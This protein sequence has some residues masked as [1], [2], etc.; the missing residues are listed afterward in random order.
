MDGDISISS[1]GQS[2]SYHSYHSPNHFPLSL[3]FYQHNQRSHVTFV[4]SLGLNQFISFHSVRYH[5]PT[6][7]SSSLSLPVLTGPPSPCLLFRLCFSGLH[8]D[9]CY[10]WEARP[11]SSQPFPTSRGD[12]RFRGFRLLF[13]FR[14]FLFHFWQHHSSILL[15]FI[16]FLWSLCFSH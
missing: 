4:F 16:L 15:H 2:L 9:P 1:S 10:E 14:L 8:I 12:P 11:Q 3:P 6:S 13:L 7:P 5:L